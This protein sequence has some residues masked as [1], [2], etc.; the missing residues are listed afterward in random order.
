MKPSQERKR[1][2]DSQL[3]DAIMSACAAQCET[4]YAR[5][6]TM[7][8]DWRDLRARRLCSWIVRKLGFSMYRHAAHMYGS[9]ALWFSVRADARSVDKALACYQQDIGD[10][11]KRLS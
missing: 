3:T 10:V 9:S 2:Y 6:V 1:P 7:G 5:A 4:T 11:L 8:S